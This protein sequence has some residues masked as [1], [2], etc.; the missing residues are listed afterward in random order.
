MCSARASA[1]SSSPPV[2]ATAARYVAAW[3]RSGTVRWPVGWSVPRSTPLIT[4]REVPMP[5]TSAPILTSMSQ[6]STTSGSR[7]ALSIVVVPEANTAA[8]TMFSVAPTLGNENAMSAPCSRS[9]V[10]WSSPCENLNWAPIASRP[11]TCMSIG[12]APKSSPPGIES[13]TSPQRV[14]SG[15]RTLIDALIRSTSSY[16]A[17]GIRPP[18]FVITSTPGSGRC[19][20]TPSASSSSPMI[21]T[22]VRSG[23]LVSSYTPSASRLAAISLSTEFLA[24]GTRIVPCSGPTLRTVIWLPGSVIARPVCSG[25]GRCRNATSTNADDRAVVADRPSNG[26]ARTQAT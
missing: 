25:R 15:P 14:S 23:T 22:S 9:H 2:T 20:D 10:A 21:D 6:R 4:S 7:A 16:G 5:S 19:D 18:R 11:S 1:T 3:I 26:A 13:R 17:T 12:R 8:V 24:P